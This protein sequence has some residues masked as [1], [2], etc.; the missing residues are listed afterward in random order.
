MT[1][2][3]LNTHIRDN[4]AITLAGKGVGAAYV[5][6]A[7]AANSLVGIAASARNFLRMA[8][9]TALEWVSEDNVLPWL[10]QIHPWGLS[11]SN[12]NFS[13]RTLPASQVAYCATLD[14]SG[15]QDDEVTWPVVLAQGTWAVYVVHGSETDA[16]VY[17]VQL[18]TVEVGTIDSYA[19]SGAYNVIGSVTSIS[20]SSTGKKELKLKMATKHASSSAYYGR[21]Q[22]ITLLRT[23]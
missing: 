17:S 16:G 7:D 11:A 1:A 21:I 12:V 22:G 8:S 2:A 19:G 20:V 13:T 9:A 3:V 18:D 4:L 10:I 6:Y 15:V 5:V 14:S 23:A